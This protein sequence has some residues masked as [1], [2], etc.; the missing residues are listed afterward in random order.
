MG[1][2]NYSNSH[3][4][5]RDRALAG[6]F[7]S[8]LTPPLAGRSLAGTTIQ[9]LRGS[10]M[11]LAL[12]AVLRSRRRPPPSTPSLPGVAAR[13][14]DVPPPRPVHPASP[15][16]GR[17]APPRPAGHARARRGHPRR[18]AR[19]GLPRP[20]RRPSRLAHLE[21]AADPRR[22]RRQQARMDGRTPSRNGRRA[23][24]G[25]LGARARLPRPPLRHPARGRGGAR[26]APHRDL[27]G[28]R[29]HP[30]IRAAPR[31]RDPRPHF[32][33]HRRPQP[34][35]PG[36]PRSRQLGRP[37]AVGGTADRGRGPASGGCA[38][39]RAPCGGELRQRRRASNTCRWRT[40]TVTRTG[41][42]AS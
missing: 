14:E 17:G 12:P 39:R 18:V 42:S 5:A 24:A 6:S 23:A 22:R 38:A 10:P 7:D 1:A 4:A 25:R 37:E 16:R 30:A 40:A 36:S 35:Q 29:P 19:S 15:A 41:W 9:R 27:R 21:R 20:P 8:S 26:A 13:R 28:R 32:Q 2:G 3:L 33:R 31:R 11:R 34:R